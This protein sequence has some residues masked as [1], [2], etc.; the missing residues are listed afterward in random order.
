MFEAST[1]AKPRLP[2][3]QEVSRWKLAQRRVESKPRPARSVPGCLYQRASRPPPPA[4]GHTGGS[5]WPP[6]E[7]DFPFLPFQG[8]YRLRSQPVGRGRE[9]LL[10]VGSAVG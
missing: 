8:V 6:V 1:Y 2:S 7:A 4:P 10:A 5:A 3:P 9:S